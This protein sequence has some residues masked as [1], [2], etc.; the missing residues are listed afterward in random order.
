MNWPLFDT[1]I[2]LA[3][4]AFAA[5]LVVRFNFWIYRT[6]GLIRRTPG[7]EL[8]RQRWTQS[9]RTGCAIAAI[10]FMTLGSGILN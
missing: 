6:T 10:V 9:V 2:A 5:P 8:H 3:A 4:V 1:G 7:W